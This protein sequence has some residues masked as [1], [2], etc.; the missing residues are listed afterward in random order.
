M[1]WTRELG[2]GYSSFIAAGPH[3]FTQA[4]TLYEQDVVCLDA[5]TGRILWST[6]KV[7]RAN[8]HFL[9]DFVACYFS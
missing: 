4:Q 1:L 3:V 2:Q 8:T 9:A 7:G 6:D 5:E